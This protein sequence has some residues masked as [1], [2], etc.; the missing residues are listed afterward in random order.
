MLAQVSGQVAD[1]FALQFE[2]LGNPLSPEAAFVHA[3]RGKSMVLWSHGLWRLNF[4][5]LIDCNWR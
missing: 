4:I 3:L 5:I 2:P 1:C